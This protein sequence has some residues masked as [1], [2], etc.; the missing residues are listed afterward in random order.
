MLQQTS[1]ATSYA[2]SLA[3]KS[4]ET[5]TSHTDKNLE[6]MDWILSKML[7]TTSLLPMKHT[8][9][10]ACAQTYTVPAVQAQAPHDKGLSGIHKGQGN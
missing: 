1:D 5:R 10:H 8:C 9:T 7:G 6:I 3:K 2:Y 4:T